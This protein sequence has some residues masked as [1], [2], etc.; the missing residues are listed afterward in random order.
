MLRRR[1]FASKFY[2]GVKKENGVLLAHAWLEGDDSRGFT[3][4]GFSM[5][6]IGKAG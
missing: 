6:T 5:R 1:G 2:L 3:P 4:L